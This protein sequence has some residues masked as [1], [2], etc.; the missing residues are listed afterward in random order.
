MRP[1]QEEPLRRACGGGV[2]AAQVLKL[3]KDPPP[4]IQKGSGRWL[5]NG[6]GQGLDSRDWQWNEALLETQERERALRAAEEQEREQ[7]RKKA[8]AETE[9]LRRQEQ[10][11]QKQADLRQQRLEALMAQKAEQRRKALEQAEEHKKQQE[12]AFSSE[13]VRRKD[14]EREIRAMAWEEEAMRKDLAHRAATAEMLERWAVAEQ[15]A[16]DLEESEAAKARQEQEERA[17]AEEASRQADM[18]AAERVS[19][20]AA[21]A[22]SRAA[23]QAAEDAAWAKK[24]RQSKEQLV[25]ERASAAEKEQAARRA[26]A[27]REVQK[28]WEDIS[29]VSAMVVDEAIKKAAVDFARI[30]AE[31][32]ARAAAAEAQR[33]MQQLAQERF[34]LENEDRHSRL[35]EIHDAELSLES[36]WRSAVATRKAVEHQLRVK[37][38]AESQAM[39]RE[40]TAAREMRL[41]EQ[42]SEAQRLDRSRRE[43]EDACH[44]Y[45]MK[46]LH[47]IVKRHEIN[48]Q[49]KRKLEAEAL[50]AAEIAQAE[51]TAKQEA[52]L[53]EEGL[54]Q[55]Q[56]NEAA[57]ARRLAADREA[58]YKA[59]LHSSELRREEQRQI[60]HRLQMER[61]FRVMK[62][63]HLERKYNLDA[64]AVQRQ[65]EYA[66]MMLQQAAETEREVNFKR[67]EEQARQQAQ[68]AESQRRAAEIDAK[69][70]K[71]VLAE[72][73]RREK[74]LAEEARS[75]EELYRQ[76]RSLV[77]AARLNEA[78]QAT[79]E[80]TSEFCMQPAAE[81]A[82]LGRCGGGDTLGSDCTLPETKEASPVNMGAGR[83]MHTA[84]ELLAFAQSISGSV[85]SVRGLSGPLE[86]LE[87][88]GT[89]FTS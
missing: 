5:G 85:S 12:Q 39:S 41:V 59:D 21:E 36:D 75:F 50:Q 3:V 77:S 15:M 67:L 44:A 31:S 82:G 33:L 34:C 32:E 47:R 87:S 58:M 55:K 49:R 53:R 68:L 76:N 13:V 14:R 2:A 79:T 11:R 29:M 1:L 28:R 16:R 54:R 57:E 73:R 38:T 25:R 72:A 62:A 52:A 89:F 20:M 7:Q 80:S 78:T 9:A 6:S 65:V 19:M 30:I 27:E 64:A 51:A 45:T 42:R 4:G 70:R 71:E 56:L 48:E 74:I 17:A 40:D 63:Q 18:E 24:V 83:L 8:E 88:S 22:A 43:T 10:E 26:A 61:D 66:E 35:R 46:L 37:E 23:H 60:R 81:T 86:T 84:G 69:Q